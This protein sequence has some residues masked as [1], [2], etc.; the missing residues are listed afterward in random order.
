LIHFTNDRLLLLATRAWGNTR[1]IPLGNA[2]EILKEM[3]A[4]G[5]TIVI[6]GHDVFSSGIYLCITEVRDV[7][8][9]T[10]TDCSIV[11]RDVPF[12]KKIQS[13]LLCALLKFHICQTTDRVIGHLYPDAIMLLPLKEVGILMSKGHQDVDGFAVS[14]SYSN[15][16][17]FALSGFAEKTRSKKI[18]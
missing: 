16:A 7:G 8:T 13:I 11:S 6:G 5:A 10:R 2:L 17:P 14:A 4:L 12:S 9:R 18:L 1:S 15:D 3:F